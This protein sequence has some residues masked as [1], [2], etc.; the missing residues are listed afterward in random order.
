MRGCATIRTSHVVTRGARSLTSVSTRVRNFLATFETTRLVRFAALITSSA[1]LRGKG[2]FSF[3]LG[4][5][6]EGVSPL[7][8]CTRIIIRYT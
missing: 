4:T 6:A 1:L 5:C 2:S 7:M 3:L 8:R